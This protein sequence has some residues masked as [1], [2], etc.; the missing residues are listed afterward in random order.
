ML[1]A[2]AAAGASQTVGAYYAAQSQRSQLGLQA[3]IAEI[4][5]GQALKAG[6]REQQR[7]RL[8]TGQLKSRQIA[9]MAANGV[10]LNEGSP[11]AVLT[12]TDVLGEIDAQ[13]IKQNAVM[14]AWGHRT[15]ATM[16]RANAKA[17]SPGMAAAST[18]VGAAS[19]VASTWMRFNSAGMTG[20]PS[21]K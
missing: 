17:I 19:Q 20:K 10:A 5:A 8:A 18:L 6:E 9:S 16:A 15:E 3:D 11:N 12:S 7:S 1:G 2:Q 4:Q 14:Q 13:T 21:G